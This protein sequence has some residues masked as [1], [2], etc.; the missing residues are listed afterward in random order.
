MI[1][2]MMTG[3]RILPFECLLGGVVVGVFVTSVAVGDAEGTTAMVALVVDAVALRE[4]ITA[5][6]MDAVALRDGVA[7]SVKMYI[8]GLE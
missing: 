4:G 7:Q 1:P 3:C 8:H 2:V 6:V 5:I